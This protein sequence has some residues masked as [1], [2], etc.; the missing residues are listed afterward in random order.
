MLEGLDAISWED[1]DTM[2]GSA[3]NVPNLLRHCSPRKRNQTGYSRS[4]QKTEK[5]IKQNIK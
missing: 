1:L 4:K 5:W 2:Y 3:A